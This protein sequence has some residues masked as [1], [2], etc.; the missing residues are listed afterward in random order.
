MKESEEDSMASEKKV[1]FVLV[2]GRSDMISLKCA[3]EAAYPKKKVI[4]SP[5]NG[6]ITTDGAYSHI[7]IK[8]RIYAELWDSLKKYCLDYDDVAEIIHVIDTDGAYIEDKRIIENTNMKKTRYNSKKRTI[9]TRDKCSIEKRNQYK[10]D[11]VDCLVETEA[12]FGIPYR[13]FY[14]ACNLD[15][16]LYNDPNLKHGEKIARAKKFAAEYSQNLS[17]FIDFISNSPFS[18][19]ND[20]EESW[21]KVRFHESGLKSISRLT[22][23]GIVFIGRSNVRHP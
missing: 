23:L 5:Y 6:D 15:H 3:F 7:N 11:A 13:V 12:L 20:Y 8:E 21:N 22:N 14:M 9:I 4:V 2:E 18:E 16:V 19:V 1:I 17:A 10:R